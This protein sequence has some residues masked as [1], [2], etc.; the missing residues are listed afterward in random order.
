MP[1]PFPGPL[2][3]RMGGG[4]LQKRVLVMRLEAKE[5][6]GTDVAEAGRQ[7]RPKRTEARPQGRAVMRSAGG[8]DSV[9]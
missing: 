6:R 2:V 7:L 5:R 4:A 3:A 1:A 9:A 8:V